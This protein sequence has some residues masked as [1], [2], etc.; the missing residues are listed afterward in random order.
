MPH[1]CFS[2]Y[3]LLLVL[4]LPFF[5]YGLYGRARRSGM[6]ISREAFTPL[7]NGDLQVTYGYFRAQERRLE[8]IEK[9]QTRHIPF[10]Q[11]QGLLTEVRTSRKIHLWLLLADED[12]LHLGI[13]TGHDLKQ[14]GINGHLVAE[15]VAGQGEAFL[16][17]LREHRWP[18]E[19]IGARF[20][21]RF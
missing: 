13:V 1:A 21:Y 7:P 2:T 19:L 14:A 17:A 12:P 3:T 18:R 16:L 5:L 10:E 11:M 20:E 8:W 6:L 4:V 9:D 15:T